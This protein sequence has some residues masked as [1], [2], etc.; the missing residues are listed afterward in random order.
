MK[1]GL[2]VKRG[3]ARPIGYPGS[4]RT[5]AEVQARPSTIDSRRHR[6]ANPSPTSEKFHGSTAV[7]ITVKD[8]QKSAA[9]YRDVV[10]FGVDRTFERDGRLVLVALKAGDI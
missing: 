2:I 8:I 3:V 9:W 1:S 7:S 4:N 5:R 6:M 10:G